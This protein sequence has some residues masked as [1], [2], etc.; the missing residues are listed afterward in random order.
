MEEEIPAPTL[1]DPSKQLL[2]HS[3]LKKA[4]RTPLTPRRFRTCGGGWEDRWDSTANNSIKSF[5]AKLKMEFIYV[6]SGES[7]ALSNLNGK[8]NREGGESNTTIRGISH[9]NLPLGIN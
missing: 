2:L 8:K 5:F 7:H 9:Y 4:S 1:R 6:V 3:E